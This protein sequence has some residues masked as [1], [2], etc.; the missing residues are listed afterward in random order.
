MLIPASEIN[1][2]SLAMNLSSKVQPMLQL[3]KLATVATAV[4]LSIH[5]SKYV[6]VSFQVV[7][8][9]AVALKLSDTRCKCK[10]K[11]GPSACHTGS[12]ELCPNKEPIAV[13]IN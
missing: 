7:G 8:V 6:P 3:H 13:F 2:S 10:R 12:Y 1:G 9:I 4:Y 5:S 11:A